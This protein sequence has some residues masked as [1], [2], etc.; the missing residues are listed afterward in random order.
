LRDARILAATSR[1]HNDTDSEK[2]ELISG[3][4]A[5]RTGTG[6]YAGT[7]PLTMVRII[8]RVWPS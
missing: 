2:P 7:S 5:G 4:S 1:T 6:C 8:S 3:L